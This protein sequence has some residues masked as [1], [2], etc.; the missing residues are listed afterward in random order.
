MT[1]NSNSDSNALAESRTEPIAERSRKSSELALFR[2]GWPLLYVATVAALIWWYE[3]RPAQTGLGDLQGT[4]REVTGA[5]P[6][7][8]PTDSYLQVDSNETWFVS[9]REQDWRVLRS[10]ISVRPARNCFV[11]RRSFGSDY[12]GNTI[13]TEY[14]VYLK[15]GAFYHLA[16]LADLDPVNEPKVRKFRKGDALPDAAAEAIRVYTDGAVSRTP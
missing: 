11:V 15:D 4:W 3:F 14:V 5:P 6:E 9:A 7:E 16:G 2:W 10:R 8:R 1:S 12:G 13:E